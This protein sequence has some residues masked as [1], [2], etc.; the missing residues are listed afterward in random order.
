MHGRNA[1]ADGTRG[2]VHVGDHHDYHGGR[3]AAARLVTGSVH[4]D[5]LRQRLIALCGDPGSGRTYA[6]LS[7]LDEVTRGRVERL[8]P[9]TEL[10]RIDGADLQAEHG[11]RVEITGDGVFLPEQRPADDGRHGDRERAPRLPGARSPTWVGPGGPGRSADRGAAARLGARGDRSGRHQGLDPPVG[12]RRPARAPGRSGGGPAARD[13]SVA[14]LRHGA[15]TA[16]LAAAVVAAG[17]DPGRWMLEQCRVLGTILAVKYRWVRAAVCCLLLGAA[18]FAAA[19]WGGR[20]LS[21]RASGPGCQ[22]TSF[23]D[24][25]RRCRWDAMGRERKQ[26]AAKP[27]LPTRPTTPTTKDPPK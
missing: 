9:R 21:R 15:D 3:A 25:T 7:L 10:R 24:V 26:G 4:R 5:E 20:A 23:R 27:P 19:L 1:A 2:D 14:T 11:Y 16:G 18:A 12:R 6:A 22:D 17:A 8:D 13:P